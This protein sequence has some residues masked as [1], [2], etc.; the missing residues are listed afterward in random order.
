[1]YQFIKITSPFAKGLKLEMSVT[2]L[3]YTLPNKTVTYK[4]EVQVTVHREK[5]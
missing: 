2:N 3:T 1:M 5:F 4:F